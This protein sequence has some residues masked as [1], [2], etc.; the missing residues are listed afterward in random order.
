MAFLIHKNTKAISRGT[1]A[2]QYGVA[3]R[4]GLVIAPPHSFTYPAFFMQEMI[5]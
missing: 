3:V 1:S 5:P 4:V 2:R